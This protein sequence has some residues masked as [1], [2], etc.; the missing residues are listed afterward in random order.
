MAK[1]SKLV[2]TF[3]D[4]PIGSKVQFVGLIDPRDG[5][6]RFKP[7]AKRSKTWHFGCQLITWQ[8]NQGPVIREPIYL[9]KQR[10]DDS[11]VM[12]LIRQ[13]R[14]GRI[15]QFQGSRP[16][17][18]ASLDKSLWYVKLEGPILKPK[19]PV[20]IAKEAELYEASRVHKFENSVFGLLELDEQF[21]YFQGNASFRGT[22]MYVTF[23]TESVD[24]LKA[25]I[26]QA[27]PL[28]KKRQAWFSA[29]RQN[30]YRY[31][32]A[33]LMGEWWQNDSALTEK[34]FYRFLGWPVGV[35]FHLKEGKFWYSLGGWSEELF[36][37]HGIDAVGSTLS[38]ME[39]IF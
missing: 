9:R 33:N 20:A 25:I 11:L 27:T 13:T 15:I 19:N 5:G 17:D 3:E 18:T 1:R 8:A 26:K 29:W 30:I 32:L 7:N 36:T 12:R 21:S 24:E 2:S 4:L 23:E 22:E 6:F 38:K 16:S 35:N 28:W 37:D 34:N 14:K 39:V 31:Y 10:L